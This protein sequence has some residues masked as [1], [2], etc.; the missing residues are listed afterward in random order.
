MLGFRCWC[1]LCAESC[2]EY[3]CILYQRKHQP[4]RSG[5][6]HYSPD[7]RYSYF[8]G[9]NMAFIPCFLCSSHTEEWHQTVSLWWL[10]AGILQGIITGWTGLLLVS[11]FL[12][13][14]SYLNS[15]QVVLSTGPLLPWIL[16]QWS[17]CLIIRSLTF[18]LFEQ[19]SRFRM[20]HWWIS[21]PAE[22]TGI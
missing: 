3:S 1:F 6:D 15:S 20:S 16:S 17:C 18:K 7:Q 12:I 21:W 10:P 4:F 5:R 9:R 2:T 22:Y 11:I 13:Y 14:V 19:C 8:P